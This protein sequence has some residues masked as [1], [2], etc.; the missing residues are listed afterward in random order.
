M[1]TAEGLCPRDQ[2][3]CERWWGGG[4]SYAHIHCGDLTIS[5]SRSSPALA[6]LFSEFRREYLACRGLRF[7]F[8]GKAIL[9][10]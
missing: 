2:A 5:S 8:S 4:V 7:P 9:L 6:L 10:G 3:A 1:K